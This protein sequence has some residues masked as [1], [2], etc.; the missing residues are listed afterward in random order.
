[1]SSSVCR[2]NT[3]Y[4]LYPLGIGSETW[5]IYQAIRPAGAWR[6]EY[7]YILKLILLI[8]IPGG[9]PCILVWGWVEAYL[10]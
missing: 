8:Y 7:E 3:F 6:V 10:S 4:V 5:L 2:Y 9:W 1:M